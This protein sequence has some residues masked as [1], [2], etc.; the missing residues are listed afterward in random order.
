M[1]ASS[2]HR[3]P[4]GGYPGREIVRNVVVG[5]DPAGPPLGRFGVTFVITES[6]REPDGTLVIDSMEIQ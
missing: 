3:P 5:F 2:L 1:S 4:H 6:H